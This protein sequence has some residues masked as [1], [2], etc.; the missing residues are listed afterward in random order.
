MQNGYMG[1]LEIL[2]HL[3]NLATVLA[4]QVISRLILREPISPWSIA[5]LALESL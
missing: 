4:Y 2:S 3:Q 1:V 5:H